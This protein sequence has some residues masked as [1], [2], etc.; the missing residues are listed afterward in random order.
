MRKKN[1]Q[2]F[3]L[4][5]LMIA[6]TLLALIVV[7]LSRSFVTAAKTNFKAKRTME[8]TTA[9]QNLLES[10]KTWD[11]EAFVADAGIKTPIAG[12]ADSDGNPYFIYE[13]YVPASD[14]PGLGALRNSYEAIVKVDPSAYLD[15]VSLEEDV[16][17]ASSDYNS[18]PMAQ[19]ANM[20]PA[21][22]A[23]YVMEPGADLS[24]AIS[25]DMD[26]FDSE[27]EDIKEAYLSAIKRELT[28]KIEKDAATGETVVKCSIKYIDG[29]DESNC[30]TPCVDHEIYR[31][32]PLPDGTR[33]QLGNLFVCFVPLYYTTEKASV[34]KETIV[35]ENQER[36]PV[37]LFL[38]QQELDIAGKDFS[39]FESTYQVNA[40]VCESYAD[41][42]V[43]ATGVSMLTNMY[44]D[45][46]RNRIVLSYKNGTSAM[47]GDMAA[48]AMHLIDGSLKDE[49]SSTVIY[50]VEVKVYK[51]GESG[52]GE[53][54]V[55]LK[56]TTSK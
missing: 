37:K 21:T 27:E 48:G 10:L 33:A 16:L 49:K 35:V 19:L 52:S 1:N 11:M 25:L 29:R 28:F 7:P 5:E 40:Q 8:A 20:S 17:K 43:S 18:I 50:D 41:D 55:V 46:A 9:G 12:V 3:S 42:P 36:L 39:S 30:Y 22:S 15:M 44:K 53:P 24:A 45:K 6:V 38:V 2:G 56:G 4:I 32:R 23:Y 31:N 47:A 14:I 34:A 54:L 13:K 51:D 26:S